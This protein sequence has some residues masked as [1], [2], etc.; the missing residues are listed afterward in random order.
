MENNLILPA[1]V[2]IPFLTGLGCWLAEKVSS[3]LPRWVA[4]A[5]MFVTL[6]LTVVLWNHG[7][8]QFALGG[9]TPEFATE[10]QM[11]WIQPLGVTIHLGLDG[12]SLLMVGLTALLGILAIG[13]S[14]NEIHTKT[15]LFHFN[16]LWSLAGVIG[17]FL[18]LDLFLFFLF[19]EVMLIPIY[20]LIALWGYQGTTKDSHIKAAT[21]FFI[22][23]QVC[24][25]IMLVGILG[26]VV[27]GYILTNGTISFDYRFLMLVAHQIPSEFAY[28]FMLCMFVGFVVKLPL[29][30]FHGWMPDAHEHAPT[31]GSIDLAGLLIKTPVYGLLRFV[32]PFFPAASEK[33]AHTAMVLGV[34]GIFYGAL[35][36]Y[37]QTDM[38]RLLAYASISHMGIVILGIYAGNLLTYQGLMILMLAHA[39]ASAALFMMCGQ[40]YDRFKTRDMRLMGGLRGQF[41]YL[42]FFLMF[43]VAALVGIPGLGNFIGEFLIL[44]GSYA[45]Y[46]VFTIIGAVS[47]VFAGLYGLILIH[48]TLFGQ[49]QKPVMLKDLSVREASL[50]LVCAFGLLWLGLYPQT[51][52]DIS[53]SSM[54]WI[55]NSYLPVQ[56]TP[57]LMQNAV[58]QLDHVEIR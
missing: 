19:W 9:K 16:L 14:W 20:F 26:L 18:S 21:K 4:S 6:A 37:R 29:F 45:R 49:A 38:K 22:Y 57:E 44:M 50:L 2:L 42:S 27:W 30:P 1:L 12:L 17:I 11:N 54:E 40:V 5:G 7:T 34:I 48:Q 3:Q 25:L 15:G 53:N 28:G 32:I 46:P 23:T 10:F 39:L 56:H 51:F 31:A 33:F 35:C 43:F 47:L 36:A 13:S 8:Y 41:P 58:S 24:G 55:A 52:L